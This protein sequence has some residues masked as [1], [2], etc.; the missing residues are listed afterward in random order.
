MQILWVN[1]VTDTS[2][3]IPIGL[4]PAKRTPWKRRTKQPGTNSGQNDLADVYCRLDDVV[5]GS[6]HLCHI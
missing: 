1:L 4:E 6:R 2:M 3:V 5:A